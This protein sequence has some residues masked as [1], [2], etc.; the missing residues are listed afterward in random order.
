MI[1]LADTWIMNWNFANMTT[2]TK[3]GKSTKHVLRRGQWPP[4]QVSSQLLFTLTLDL[5]IIGLPMDEIVVRCP[6]NGIEHPSWSD[7]TGGNWNWEENCKLW[8]SLHKILRGFI[9]SKKTQ[10]IINIEKITKG[11]ISEMMLIVPFC[12]E[13]WW[14]FWRAAPELRNVS[15]LNPI[16]S[17]LPFLLLL[18]NN[19]Y[20]PI[21]FR[22]SLHLRRYNVETKMAWIA[23]CI[24]HIVVA[25]HLVSGWGVT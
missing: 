15:K 3:S 19:H 2:V 4:R 13:Q 6:W 24:L 10:E 7:A 25:R 17:V 22:A 9:H 8:I 1:I 11:L 12:R 14:D 23:F 20:N 18:L 16:L 21:I 5:H